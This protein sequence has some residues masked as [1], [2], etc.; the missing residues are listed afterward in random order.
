VKVFNMIQMNTADF[1]SRPKYLERVRPFIDKPLIKVFTGQR[2]TGKSYLLLQTMDEIR[3][4]HPDSDIIYINM[5]HPDFDHIRTK[6]QLW[7]FVHSH[8]AATGM[9]YVFIDEVQEI[10]GFEQALRGLLAEGVYDLYCTGSNATLLSGELAT[11]LSGRYIEIA[12]Q[13]LSYKEFL[14]FHQLPDSSESLTKYTVQGGMPFLVHLDDDTRVRQEYL[15]NVVNTILF[16]DVS[17][18]FKVRNFS[19]LSNLV[20][21]IADTTG[22]LV[23]ANRISEFLKSQRTSVSTRTIIDY[24]GFLESSY[25]VHRVRRYDIAGKKV[26]EI[27]DKYYFQDLGLQ[28]ALRSY[29]PA[30][31]NKYIENLVYFHLKDNGYQV[32]VG[33]LGDKEIDFI[34]RK[35]EQVVY[36]QVALSVAEKQAFEREFGNLLQINDNHTKYVVT[37][38]EFATGNHKGIK[39]MHLRE[40]LLTDAL[41][42]A[43]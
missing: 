41:Y 19:F 18:R 32:F 21:F 7:Q 11:L 6:D 28:H 33:K 37:L 30:S 23:S 5:E 36:V 13:N 25:L 4:L 38:D 34:A 22:S 43:G 1:I 24:L 31:L 27:N 35:N 42:M 14:L 40:F 17:Q 29:D 16:K 3:K 15:T 20:A 8:T 26:F 10:E 39:H 9:C 12:V 2:R